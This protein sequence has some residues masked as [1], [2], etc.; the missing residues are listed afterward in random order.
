MNRINKN[1]DCIAYKRNAQLKIYEEIRDLT[2]DEEVVYFKQSIVS[3]SLLDWWDSLKK[4]GQV[5]ES[6][7]FAVSLKEKISV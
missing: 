7:M 3:S 4:F 1:F 6:P 5:K 2:P